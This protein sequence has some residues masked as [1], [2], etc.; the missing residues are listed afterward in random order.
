I[1]KDPEAY[2]EIPGYEGVPPAIVRCFPEELRQH[3]YYCSN[4]S[5]QDYQFRVP[6]T[7]WDESSG[8][9]HW[10]NRAEGQPFFAVFNY[11]G[12][13]ESGTFPETK[14]KPSVVAPKDV[15]VPPIYPDTKNVRQ[16]MARTYDNIA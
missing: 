11:G 13:H 4:N 5:K 16:A 12:T 14:P 7:V 10:R 3:G 1:E 15:L 6:V 2:R 9:A 8:R